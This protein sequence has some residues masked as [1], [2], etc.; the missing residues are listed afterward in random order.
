M[1]VFLKLEI[2]VPNKCKELFKSK[3][4]SALH[5]RLY[6]MQKVPKKIAPKIKAKKGR[7]KGNRNFKIGPGGIQ[8]HACA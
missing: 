1:L 7:K 4:C 6:E 2:F 8:T 3:H 5:S